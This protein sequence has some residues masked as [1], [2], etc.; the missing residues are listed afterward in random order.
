MISNEQHEEFLNNLDKEIKSFLGDDILADDKPNLEFCMNRF[1]VM[2]NGKQYPIVGVKDGSSPITEFY[3]SEVTLRWLITYMVYHTTFLQ[4]PMD[5]DLQQIYSECLY[6]CFVLKF[7]KG[8]NTVDGVT[9][10]LEKDC[11][12]IQYKLDRK[13]FV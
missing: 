3:A 11:E 5:N 8:I 2:R 7:T 1:N 10:I 12:F 9:Y 13:L 4:S 6:L